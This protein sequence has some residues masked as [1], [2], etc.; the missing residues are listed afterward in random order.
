M[1]S[2]CV[3]HVFKMCSICVQNVK[4]VMQCMANCNASVE[5]KNMGSIHTHAIQAKFDMGGRN[6]DEGGKI[7]MEDRGDS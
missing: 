3:K 5:L 2:K 1:C 4:I 7:D 6:I